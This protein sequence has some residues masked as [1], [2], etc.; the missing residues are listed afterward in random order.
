MAE[1]DL[2]VTGRALGERGMAVGMD[3]VLAP[4]GGPRLACGAAHLVTADS[5]A[6]KITDFGI[7][8]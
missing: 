2:M 5:G 4:G 8:H 1:P 3:A 7:D 6:I